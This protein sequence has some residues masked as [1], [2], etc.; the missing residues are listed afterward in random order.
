MR[1]IQFSCCWFFILSVNDSHVN[2]IRRHLRLLN[3]WCHRNE[4]M[5]LFARNKVSTSRTKEIHVAFNLSNGSTWQLLS[6]KQRNAKANARNVVICEFKPMRRELT[7]MLACLYPT[8][9]L[10]FCHNDK[11][12]NLHLAQSSCISPPNTLAF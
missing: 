7:L 1:W 10:S 12:S 8:S 2:L 6:Y 3:F 11:I 4:N 9:V 5:S